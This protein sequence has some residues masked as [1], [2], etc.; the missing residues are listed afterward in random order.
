MYVEKIPK[1]VKQG[2]KKAAEIYM[3]KNKTHSIVIATKK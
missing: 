1:Y 3:V 2:K